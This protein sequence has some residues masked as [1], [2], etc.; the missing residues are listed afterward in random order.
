MPPLHVW[1]LVGDRNDSI[2]ALQTP[3]RLVFGK[4]LVFLEIQYESIYH[5][6]T[7]CGKTSGSRLG[8]KYGEILP[9]TD[10]KISTKDMSAMHI[11]ID[12]AHRNLPPTT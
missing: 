9:R 6:N 4:S 1:E 2:S 10:R 5:F 11:F 8:S 12:R 7:R 3:F